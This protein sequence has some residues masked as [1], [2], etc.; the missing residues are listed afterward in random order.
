MNSSFTAFALMLVLAAAGCSAAADDGPA[1]QGAHGFCQT[2]S[3]GLENPDCACF[4][5]AMKR[6]L[7]PEIFEVFGRSVALQARGVVY[8]DGAPDDLSGAEAEFEELRNHYRRLLQ[9][10]SDGAITSDLNG[11]E[12]DLSSCGGKFPEMA[13]QMIESFTADK[14]VSAFSGIG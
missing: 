9:R 10:W 11:L 6:N 14:V 1:Y 2:N 13:P 5:K 4:A 3:E 8:S 12:S 7:D